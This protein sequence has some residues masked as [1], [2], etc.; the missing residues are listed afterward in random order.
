MSL[1]PYNS[2]IHQYF[3]SNGKKTKHFNDVKWHIPILMW[4]WTQN[5]STPYCSLIFKNST[6]AQRVITFFLVGILQV[7]NLICNFSLCA[8]CFISHSEVKWGQMRTPTSNL[9]N[10]AGDPF[11]YTVC[12]DRH[13]PLVCW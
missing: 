13:L 4:P 7:E 10:K 1:K 8:E 3:F 9:L 5:K 11:V 2:Q 6:I 12:K